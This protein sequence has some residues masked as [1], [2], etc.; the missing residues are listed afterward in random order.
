M[1]KIFVVELV[2]LVHLTHFLHPTAFYSEDAAREKADELRKGRDGLNFE[3]SVSNL[4]ID[5]LP[6]QHL[7]VWRNIATGGDVAIGQ[8]ITVEEA[9]GYVLEATQRAY[10]WMDE[11]SLK[12]VEEALRTNEPVLNPLGMLILGSGGSD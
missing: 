4:D 5:P 11:A 1:T 2:H 10:R 6:S 8:G 12:E 9:I 7:Y 3:I